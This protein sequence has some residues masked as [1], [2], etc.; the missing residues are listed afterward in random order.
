MVLLDY[1]CLLLPALELRG[2]LGDTRPL[3]SVVISPSSGEASLEFTLDKDCDFN[4][5]AW[6]YELWVPTC[7][8]FLYDG[9]ATDYL[10]FRRE[11]NSS[12]TAPEAATLNI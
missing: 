12:R 2:G 6:R 7:M 1:S 10:G 4:V 8:K 5:S 9:L 11:R 3:A